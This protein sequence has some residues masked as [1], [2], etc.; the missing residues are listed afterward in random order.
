MITIQPTCFVIDE[1]LKLL[2]NICT[3]GFTFGLLFTNFTQNNSTDLISADTSP[4]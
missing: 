3:L 1:G 4:R 2:I